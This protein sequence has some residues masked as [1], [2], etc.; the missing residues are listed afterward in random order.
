MTVPE[1]ILTGSVIFGAV[2]GYNKGFLQQISSIIGLIAGY[3]ITVMFLSQTHQ[4]LIEKGILSANSSLWLSFFTT[5]LLVFLSVKFLSGSIEKI[6]KGIG[7]NFT[8]RFAGLLLG[9]FKYFLIIMI[10]FCFLETLG[11][12]SEKNSSSNLISFISLFKTVL[13]SFVSSK[14][15]NS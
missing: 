8:N 5:V 9:A 10:L 4:F 15:V 1:Y 12:I 2:I 13:F 14:T 3:L 11:F 6:L 7:L